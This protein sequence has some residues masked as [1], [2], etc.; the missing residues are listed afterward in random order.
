SDEGP[1]RHIFGRK[2]DAWELHGRFRD[3]AD[4]VDFAKQQV[5]KLKAFVADAQPCRIA[6]GDILSGVGFLNAF[7]PGREAEEEVEWVLHIAID[8]DDNAKPPA[9]TVDKRSPEDYAHLI[10]DLL[11]EGTKF[12]P[13][14]P[15]IDGSFLDVLDSMFAAITT[16]VGA[17]ND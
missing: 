5:E 6:W 11:S 3:R 16:A 9:R 4:G 12:P 13:D 8:S 7:D 10:V 15:T 2:Y 1:T 14:L 17:L